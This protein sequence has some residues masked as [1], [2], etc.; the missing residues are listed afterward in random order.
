[1]SL[2]CKSHDYKRL[3]SRNT[4]IS[5]PEK[6]RSFASTFLFDKQTGCGS[7]A[8]GRRRER[9]FKIGPVDRRIGFRLTKWVGARRALARGFPEVEKKVTESDPPECKA[10]SFT[11]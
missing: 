2:I 5:S 7:G 9:P 10:L 4:V 1:M 8:E 11:R 6:V 3:A